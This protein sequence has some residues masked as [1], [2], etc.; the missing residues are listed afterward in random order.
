MGPI[1]FNIY[2]DDITNVQLS[3]GSK[4]TL[5]ANDRL[6]LKPLWCVKDTSA[7][8]DDVSSIASWLFAAILNFNARKNKLI[9]FSSSTSAPDFP[10]IS[11]A[12]EIIEQVHVVKYLGVQLDSKLLYTAHIAHICK[13]T[14][15]AIGVYYNK[16]ACFAPLI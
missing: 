12:D 3:S 8:Q 13:N 7:L 2:I 15:R 11:L 14:R 5:Y 4:L 10:A 1:L 9:S 6:L 16:F